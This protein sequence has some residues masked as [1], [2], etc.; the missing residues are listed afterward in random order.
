MGTYLASSNSA[1][2]STVGPL[3][4]PDCGNES[5]YRAQTFWVHAAVDFVIPSEP[6]LMWLH[7]CC[8]QFVE[9]FHPQPLDAAISSFER[10]QDEPRKKNEEYLW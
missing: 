5:F 3:P 6:T 9:L 2:H 1:V 4:I 8:Q 10:A 7:R